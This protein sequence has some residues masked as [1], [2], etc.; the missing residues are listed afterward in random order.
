MQTSDVFDIKTVLKNRDKNVLL[1][2]QD[3]L[4]IEDLSSHK[5]QFSTLNKAVA[6]GDYS[7]FPMVEKDVAQK[8]IRQLKEDTDFN[9][10]VSYLKVGSAVSELKLSAGKNLVI[11]EL[12][13]TETA[14]QRSLALEK[15]DQIMASVVGKMDAPF[16]AV[17]T[18][19]A[20]SIGA[21]EHSRVGRSLKQL[22]IGAP[23]LPDT[24]YHNDCVYFYLREQM[25]ISLTGNEGDFHD[26]PKELNTEPLH[27]CAESSQ[28]IILRYSNV[29]IGG[30]QFYRLKLGFNFVN[31]R[32]SWSCPSVD[33]S[34]QKDST[35]HEEKTVLQMGQA[36][37]V[38]APVGHSF[39]CSEPMLY[40]VA[41]GNDTKTASSASSSM[42]L[43]LNGV[44]IQPFMDGEAVNF[45][46]SWDCVGFF[47][48]GI[49]MGILTSGLAITI[50][51]YGMAMITD[52][53]T[54][55][56]FDDPKGKPIMLTTAH[57]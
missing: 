27:V 33:V 51:A 57:E 28:G 43:R 5:A 34:L 30:D 20:S 3:T 15:A 8:L 14:P 38:S 26:I 7:Y 41:G 11:V 40:H 9:Y 50:L 32:G 42:I 46:P 39:A 56:R 55:D 45:G 47:S 29:Q 1:F 53:K 35:D 19:H 49:W 52:I 12:P 23:S 22:S 10:S 25:D 13:K 2:L 36:I 18:A 24:F 54:M 44:Q 37:D 48:P 17:Y 4:S 16:Y 6:S 31:V 21:P